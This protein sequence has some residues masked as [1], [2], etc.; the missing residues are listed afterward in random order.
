MNIIQDTKKWIA[1]KPIRSEAK[2]RVLAFPCACAGASFFRTWMP[3]FP[4][5][6]D[7]LPIQLPGRETR[8]T[9]KRYEA[10]SELIPDLVQG[11]RPLLDKPYIFFGHSLGALITY[12]LT[13][14]LQEAGVPGP[15]H[16]YVAAYRAP[17]MPNP[18]PQ[19]HYL[20]DSAF[21]QALMEYRGMPEEVRKNAE[22]LKLLAPIAKADFKLHETYLHQPGKQLDCPIT[23]LGG[24]EDPFVSQVALQGWAE[25]TT[26]KFCLE[27]YPGGHNFIT[28]HVSTLIGT[29]LKKNN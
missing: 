6:V 11:L 4:T 5:E 19:L 17:H 16:I 14:A 27:M 8:F 21:L 23:V 20:S 12:N 7:F 15:Q 3:Q 18:N 26:A 13:R 10:M 9:E 28:E 2:L 29:M 1:N 25:L 24:S 22:I